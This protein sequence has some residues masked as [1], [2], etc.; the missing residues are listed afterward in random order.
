MKQIEIEGYVTI[1]KNETQE[2]FLDK[3]VNFLEYNGWYFGGGTRE[4]INSEAGDVMYIETL[5]DEDGEIKPVS[6]DEL[7]EQGFDINKVN[8]ED[9]SR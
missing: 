5:P 4:H 6:T 3:F 9:L 1:K 2:M 7:V 8:F